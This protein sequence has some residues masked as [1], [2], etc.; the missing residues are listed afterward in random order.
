MVFT[1]LKLGFKT[2]EIKR[3]PSRC[4]HIWLWKKHPK[5]MQGRGNHLLHLKFTERVGKYKEANAF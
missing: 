3:I 4:L 1:F 5:W 2:I